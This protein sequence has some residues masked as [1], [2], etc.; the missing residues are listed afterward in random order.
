[1]LFALAVTTSAL[2]KHFGPS[3]P[4][5][6][7]SESNHILK[8]EEVKAFS[9]ITPEESKNRL[10]AIFDKIDK[11]NIEDS[12]TPRSIEITGL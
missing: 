2:P 11:V 3:N 5:Y 1:M 10:A 7:D 4:A 9:S 8:T 12:D 6:P